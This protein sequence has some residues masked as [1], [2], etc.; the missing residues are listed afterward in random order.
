MNTIQEREHWMNELSYCIHRLEGEAAQF[1]PRRK[2]VVKGI[3]YAKCV[4]Q[5]RE[6]D[7][8]HQVA[9]AHIRGEMRCP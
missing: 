5:M 8:R 9:T 2:D 4:L 7:L 6:E 1:S 3:R